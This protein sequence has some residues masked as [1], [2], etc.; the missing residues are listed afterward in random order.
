MKSDLPACRYPSIVAKW[1]IDSRVRPRH[2]PA[3]WLWTAGSDTPP[4]DSAYTNANGGRSDSHGCTV[5]RDA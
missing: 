4:S 5:Y 1:E 3:G 2:S